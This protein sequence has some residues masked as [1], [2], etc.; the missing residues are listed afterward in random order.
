MDV[1][2]TRQLV[3]E[4]VG[5]YKGIARRVTD[6][7]LT[8]VRRGV[9]TRPG[10]WSP[11]QA[12]RL[13][14]EAAAPVLNGGTWFSHRSAALIHGLP[15]LLAGP[16]PVEVIRTMGG[17]G[18]RS[19]H[20]HARAAALAD[21]DV[22]W[23]GGLPVTGLARTVVDLARSLPFP[24]AVMV[25]DH[26][27]R[28]GVSQ[29]D[30]LAR[31]SEGRGQRKAERAILFADG[32]AE[33]PPESESRARIALAGLP[34]PEIQ[35]EL[36][37]DTGE[38]IA[39]PDFYWRGK[40]LAGEYDGEGKYTGAYGV[41][42]LDAIRNEKRRHAALEEHGYAVL[43]WDRTTLR[44][45]GEFERRVRTALPAV[46]GCR[47]TRPEAACETNARLTT[48]RSHN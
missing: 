39:R 29:E 41:T 9:V 23:V 46:P 26:A 12:L 5:G 22:M 3:D 38:F 19:R 28:L 6:G 34:V 32:A 36:F 24:Q 15:L 18:N 45:P 47:R 14:I 31:L 16:E 10:E 4:T 44:Q 20:L 40:R 27:L 25:A 35:V 13:R 21:E 37:T 33:S 42:P 1:E 7:Q 2:R 17:H 11:D 48:V 30:L 8:R 43:R